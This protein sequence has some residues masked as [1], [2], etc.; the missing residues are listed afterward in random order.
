MLKSTVLKILNAYFIT[1]LELLAFFPVVL[2]FSFVFVKD[3]SSVIFAIT[4]SLYKLFGIIL[5]RLSI[6]SKRNYFLIFGFL[7]PFYIAYTLHQP[8]F[9]WIPL[10]LLACIQYFR[11]FKSTETES[12]SIFPIQLF[13]VSYLLHFGTIFY[14]Q[15]AYLFSEFLPYLTISAVMLI[16]ASI[17]ISN[18]QQLIAASLATSASTLP[19]E[20]I[21]KNLFLV[22]TVLVLIFLVTYFEEIRKAIIWAWDSFTAIILSIASFISSFFAYDAPPGQM[23]Q[24]PSELFPLEEIFRPE[25][26]IWAAIIEF[27]SQAVFI[28]LMIGLL[29]IMVSTLISIVRYILR[30]LFEFTKGSALGADIATAGFTDQKETLFDLGKI[31]NIYFEKAKTLIDK[32]LERE[33]KYEELLDNKEKILYLYKYAVISLVA[34]GYKYKRSLTPNELS[35]DAANKYPDSRGKLSDIASLYSEVRYGDKKISDEA[36]NNIKD[37]ILK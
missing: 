28:L 13:Y 32:F 24:G 3:W 4:L 18:F 1:L 36:L 26:P 33:K 25:N 8:T 31:K 14:F 10:A 30:E 16:I 23:Q 27:L 6:E 37:R 29:Y 20:I 34:S 22:S 19:K 2:V 12:A 5:G 9:T 21:R 17:L 11:G 15:R 7:A 35:E